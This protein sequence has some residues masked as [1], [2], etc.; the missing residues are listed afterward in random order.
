MRKIKISKIIVVILALALMVISIYPLF[1]LVVQSFTP[2]NETD[3]CIIP[4]QFSLRSYQHLFSSSLNS[5]A[6]VWIRALIN[7]FIV[8][9]V[10]TLVSIL[11]G[12]FVGFSLTK[13]PKFRQKKFVMNSLL[14]QMFFP[15]VMLVV[16]RYVILN[17]A[18]NTYAGMLMPMI[19]STWAVFMYINCF[20]TLPDEMFEAAKMD[21]AGVFKLMWHVAFPLTK[22]ITTIVA[23]TVFM[24]R[25]NEL[26]WDMVISPNEQYQT[27]NVL[28][29][30]K[31]SMLSTQQGVLYA[32]SVILIVPIVA[33]FLIFSKH[34][35]EG[36]NF[37]LK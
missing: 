25:W 4:T 19:I 8:C 18:T 26:M 2:W 9:I 33:L 1:Y 5:N 7:S 21:G 30:T 32:A 37:M 23:L 6:F 14:F 35:R 3:H 24:S 15:V 10:T 28:L 17:S 31:I 16:P 11:A 13:L 36:I 22:S 20:R 12:V 34:F 29:S 27:L